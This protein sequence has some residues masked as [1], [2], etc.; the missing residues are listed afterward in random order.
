MVESFSVVVFKFKDKPEEVAVVPVSW[1]CEKNSKCK[2][3]NVSTEKAQKWA[4]KGKAV[5]ENWEKHN[6]KVLKTYS[7]YDQA[8][9][10][11]N[12]AETSDLESQSD[13]NSGPNFLLFK[14]PRVAKSKN[15]VSTCEPPILNLGSTSDDRWDRID[16]QL[17]TLQTKIDNIAGEMKANITTLYN[18][19]ATSSVDIRQK[20][21]LEEI[22]A[23][24]ELEL[25]HDENMNNFKSNIARIGGL[26]FKDATRR[27][28]RN[29]LSP[30]A[31]SM[32]SFAGRT[33]S[34]FRE[35]RISKAIIAEYCVT[36]KQ[37]EQAIAD[38]LKH[39]KSQKD[40]ME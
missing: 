20:G 31:A 40:I 26:N 37:V 25:I 8:R 24:A 13:S 9:S 1:L 21:L 19:A 22:H 5:E 36:N 6:V 28:L 32:Y 14:K 11:L 29:I 15:H 30:E 18:L 33:K 4:R 35:L 7:T 10:Q 39:S 17:D 12:R 2:W 16:L 38:T 3:S 23:L 34:S 27:A